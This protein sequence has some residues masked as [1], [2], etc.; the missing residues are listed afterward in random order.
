MVYAS[1]L[2]QHA[3]QLTAAVRAGVTPAPSRYALIGGGDELE[4]Q[5]QGQEAV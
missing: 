4:L 3:G 1:I 2:S 5:Q